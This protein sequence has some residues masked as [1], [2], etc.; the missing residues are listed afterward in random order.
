LY[1]GRILPTFQGF[2]LSHVWSDYKGVLDWWSDLLD[3][4]HTA[5][6][7]TLQFTITHTHASVHSHDFTAVAR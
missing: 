5:H 4:F 3:S 1:S 7:Y 6:G 2:M